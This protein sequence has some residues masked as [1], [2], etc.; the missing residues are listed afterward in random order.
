MRGEGG[1]LR[2]VRGALVFSFLLFPAA[3]ALACGPVFPAGYFVH[4]V[5]DYRKMPSAWFPRELHVLLGLKGT[6]PLP[7]APP[8]KA[9]DRVVDAD[10]AQLEAALRTAERSDEEIATT[11]AEYQKMRCA[12]R[13][14][15][16]YMAGWERGWRNTF[17]G[18][19]TALRKAPSRPNPPHLI[20]RRLKPS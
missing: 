5:R 4:N 1:G 19:L 10:L 2:L 11:L 7:E 6:P 15:G 16:D 9:C 13:E 20:P 12:M 14:T 18:R 17:G 3:P 8:A